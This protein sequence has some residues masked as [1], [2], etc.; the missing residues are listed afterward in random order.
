MT[1]KC[2]IAL[3]FWV[4]LALPFNCAAAGT[5]SPHPLGGRFQALLDRSVSPTGLPGVVLALQ[6]QDGVWIGASGQADLATGQ[7]MTP[8]LQVRVASTTKI[9]TAALI[10]RLVDEGRLSL[11][12]TVDKWLPRHQVIGGDTITIPML[13][14]HT[15]GL[16]D[17]ETAELTFNLPLQPDKPWTTAEVLNIVN[18]HPI[19]GQGKY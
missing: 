2:L 6:D 12:D 9:F 1:R 11:S 18:A 4:I 8:D 19:T 13:L 10:M 17:H 14:H 16:F 7:P 15:S 5:N 3:S